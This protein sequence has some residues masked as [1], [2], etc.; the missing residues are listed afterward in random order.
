MQ[1]ENNQL[2]LALVRLGI[3][4]FVGQI[5]Q[6]NIQWEDL[7]DLAARQGL[8]AVIVDGIEKLPERLRPPKEVLLRWIGETLQ[9]YEHRYEQ[10][11]RT[12][13]EMSVF[14]NE[15][16]IKMMVLK[17]YDRC[18][19]WP[20]PE[21][22]PCGDIDIWQFGKQKEADELIKKERG[23]KVDTSEHHHTVYYWQDFM[24][25]NHYDMLITSAVK[26]NRQLEPILKELAMDDSRFTEVNGER[27]YLPSAD[28]NALFLL[29]HMLM[30]FVAVGI[31]FRLILD[32]AFFWE[33]HG[34]DV[35]AEW[36]MGVVDE[37][38]MSTF[39][40]IINVICVEDLGFEASI[41]P[42]VQFLPQ[43]KDQVLNDILYPEFDKKDAHKSGFFSR[44]FFKYKRWKGG[45][46]KRE[47][48]YGES[49]HEAF[50]QSIWMHITKPSSI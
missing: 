22:R 33:K 5:C 17:G 48:C 45:A 16:Q 37:F 13:A 32:W 35:N 30:H 2:F 43:L 9:N 31:S 41:F 36:F 23:V 11:R 50:W 25:E 28:F 44:I 20:K 39:F 47:L 46:W 29:R 8:S 27:V 34:K 4:K 21:H 6:E 3:G 40:N 24:V 49:S 19:D 38:N 26:T 18:L 12:I 42:S 1:L 7:E 10:Y 14:F 15:H